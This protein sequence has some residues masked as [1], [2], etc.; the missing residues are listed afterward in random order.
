MVGSLHSSIIITPQKVD[1]LQEKVE[2]LRFEVDNA[3]KG[4]M[5][6]VLLQEFIKTSLDVTKDSKDFIA[7]QKVKWRSRSTGDSEK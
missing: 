7:L 4:R 5:Q 3:N 1:G 6:R 2:S